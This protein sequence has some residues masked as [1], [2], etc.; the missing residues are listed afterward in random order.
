MY[1][2]FVIF[3]ESDLAIFKLFCAFLF[4]F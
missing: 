2:G 3:A 4:V 1:L